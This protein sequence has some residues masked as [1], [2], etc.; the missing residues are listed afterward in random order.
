[1]TYRV[2]PWVVVVSTLLCYSGCAFDELSEESPTTV[3]SESGRW[4]ASERGEVNATEQPPL[5]QLPLS[6]TGEIPSDGPAPSRQTKSWGSPTTEEE[7]SAPTVLHCRQQCES[8]SD[9]VGWAAGPI[10]SVDNYACEAGTCLYLGCTSDSQC[11][12]LYATPDF[13]C[14]LGAGANG[15]G[16]CVR[17]CDQVSDCVEDGAATTHDED[18]YLCHDQRCV[19]Q[20]C[21]DDAECREALGTDATQCALAPALGYKVC[22]STCL[23]AAD[24]DFG[25]PARRS[26][27]YLCEAGICRYQGCNDDAEC[28]GAGAGTQ[29]CRP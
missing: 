23:S 12:A 26:D 5:P 2:L 1:M 19:Y 24:C 9:C 3:L 18:N 20:G 27:N 28:A 4:S 6:E 17:S 29:V 13:V 25:T 11:A 10:T 7:P 21:Q 16:V 14:H 15:T 8:A 22:H